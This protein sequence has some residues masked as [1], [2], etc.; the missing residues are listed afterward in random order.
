MAKPSRSGVRGLFKEVRYFDSTGGKLR[1]VDALTR[2]K[3]GEKG[4][5]YALSSA[6]QHFRRAKNALGITDLRLH[7]IRHDTATKMR[8]MGIGI[9][10][11]GKVLGHT[12]ITTTARY[13]HVGIDLLTE[14]MDSVPAPIARPL[15][16][17]A[18]AE[19]TEEATPSTKV[20]AFPVR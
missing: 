20:V 12:Q 11:I 2:I 5:P 14:A 15:P 4:K 19:T 1:K 6:S 3:A 9:D 8:R 17:P 7:D 13:A 16:E 18:K 10:V